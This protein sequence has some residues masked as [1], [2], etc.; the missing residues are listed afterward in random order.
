MADPGPGRTEITPDGRPASIRISDSIRTERGVREAGFT[1]MVLP[2]ANAGAIFQEAMTRGKFQGV[3]KAQTPTG[4]RS[5]TSRPES[6]TGMVSPNILLAA[7]PQ[8]SS[9]A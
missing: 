6:C 5:V 7:P 9:T 2:Q 8:Y 3:I 4:S 1:I